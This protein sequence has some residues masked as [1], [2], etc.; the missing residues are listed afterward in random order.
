[1]AKK[2]QKYRRVT[3]EEKLESVKRVLVKGEAQIQVER[4]ILKVTNCTGTLNRW[5]REYIQ[6]GEENAFKKK[7]GR[8][9]FEDKTEEDVRYEIL[10][11]FNAFLDQEIR[12][13]MNSLNKIKKDI[14]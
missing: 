11:K 8:K 4:D 9:K 6:E 3:R 7:Q 12:T 14:Q 2:G 10:K 1:M 13:N 5:I